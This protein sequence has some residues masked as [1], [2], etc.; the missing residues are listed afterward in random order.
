MI[1]KTFAKIICIIAII[2]TVGVMIW[3]NIY[4]A[5]YRTVEDYFAALG[6][7]DERAFTKVS[8][9]GVGLNEA[10]GTALSGSG[11]TE[12]DDPDFKVKLISRE[13][14][15]DSFFIRVKLTIYNEERYT[16][17]ERVLDVKTYGVGDLRVREN[18]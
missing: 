14:N 9:G 4:S 13:K 3:A 11:F 15:G 16:E 6:R 2:G 5:P 10:L 12:E 8:D 7:G 18:R 17:E 1:N